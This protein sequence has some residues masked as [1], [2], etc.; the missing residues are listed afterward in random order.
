[1]PGCSDVGTDFLLASCSDGTTA[2]AEG[3]VSDTAVGASDLEGD[4]A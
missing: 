2:A 3:I 4:L 1:V